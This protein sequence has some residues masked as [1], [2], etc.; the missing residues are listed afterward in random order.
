MIHKFFIIAFLAGM[1]ESQLFGS[2]AEF[3]SNYSSLVTRLV[4][5]HSK[6]VPPSEVVTGTF[7]VFLKQIVSI[8]DKNQSI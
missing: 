1:A 7:F 6:N 3:T 4:K 5:D 2:D 8:D